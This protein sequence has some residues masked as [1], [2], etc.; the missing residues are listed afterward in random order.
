M[1]PPKRLAAG[2]LIGILIAPGASALAAEQNQIG[3]LASHWSTMRAQ[4]I[5]IYAAYVAGVRDTYADFNVAR[6]K[7]ANA[8]HCVTGIKET[9]LLAEEVRSYRKFHLPG[10]EA[11]Q[12]RD[13]TIFRL[14]ELCKL[15]G[16]F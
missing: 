12:L 5:V 11:M 8:A 16:D 6:R 13:W 4:D 15:G 7:G 14:N 10:D 1:H 2:I 9:E 3:Y